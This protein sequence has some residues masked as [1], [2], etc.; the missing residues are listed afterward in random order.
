[1]TTFYQLTIGGRQEFIPPK[2]N[3]WSFLDHISQR[4]PKLLDPHRHGDLVIEFA[5]YLGLNPERWG[6][7]IGP[8]MWLLKISPDLERACRKY[9]SDAR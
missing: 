4:R 8:I 2:H 3:I 9:R 6:K 7:N 1:M 5:H